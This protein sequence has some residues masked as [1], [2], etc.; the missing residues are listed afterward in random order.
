MRL[1]VEGRRSANFLKRV[2]LTST[3]LKGYIAPPKVALRSPT[4][5]GFAMEA[6]SAFGM[7]MCGI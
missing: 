4:E 3:S 5:L 1:I 2:A 7:H 6:R